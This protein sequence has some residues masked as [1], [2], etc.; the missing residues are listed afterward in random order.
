MLYGQV[1]DKTT[2]KLIWDE[3][4]QQGLKSYYARLENLPAS[5]K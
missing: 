2:M 5:V 3:E 4:D 1:L